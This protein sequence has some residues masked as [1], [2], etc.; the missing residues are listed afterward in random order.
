MSHGYDQDARAPARWVVEAVSPLLA[1]VQRVLIPG[2]TCRRMPC[3]R[4]AVLQS[5]LGLKS[6]EVMLGS[7]RKKGSEGVSETWVLG[8]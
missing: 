4:E 8:M 7:S 3:A 1:G 6:F 2:C 5:L